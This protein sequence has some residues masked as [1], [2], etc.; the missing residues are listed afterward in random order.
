MESSGSRFAVKY[1]VIIGYILVVVT[2]IIGLL[3]VYRNLVNFSET[4]VKNEDLTELI[5]VGNIINRYTRLKVHKIYILP[6]VQ[7]T[8]STDTIPYG[9]KSP[10]NSTR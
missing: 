4:R 3:A 5:I 2:M 1:V 7:Q 9:L 10:L 8:T 6:K